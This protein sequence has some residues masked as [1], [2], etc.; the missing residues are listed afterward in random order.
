MKIFTPPRPYVDAKIEHSGG[1]DAPFHPLSPCCHP[2][3][4]ARQFFRG[5]AILGNRDYDL[6]IDFIQQIADAL[7]K[8]CN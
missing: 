4:W 6:H 7:E 3:D 5:L 2:L 1:D 8:V